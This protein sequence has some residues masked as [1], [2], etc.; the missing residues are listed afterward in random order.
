MLWLS[1]REFISLLNLCW[2]EQRLHRYLAIL[3]L[4]VMKV[5]FFL[6]PRLSTTNLRL[7]RKKEKFY[8]HGK[9]N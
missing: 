9:L 8:L 7:C 2:A 1:W 4:S 5:Y 6:P 3:D